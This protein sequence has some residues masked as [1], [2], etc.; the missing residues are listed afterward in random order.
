MG[1]VPATTTPL[2]V[3]GPFLRIWRTIIYLSFAAAMSDVANPLRQARPLFLYRFW[4]DRREGNP[5]PQNAHPDPGTES[6]ALRQ[7]KVT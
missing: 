2:L 7:V 4:L 5:T 6:V 3:G 1:P